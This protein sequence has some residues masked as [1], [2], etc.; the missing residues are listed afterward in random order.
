MDADETRIVF[1]NKEIDIISQKINHFDNLRL[2]TRQITIALWVGVVGFGLN[3]S[4]NNYS[5]FLFFLGSLIPLPFWYIESTYRRYYKGWS[6]RFKAIR[7]FL[8]D[9]YYNLPD[10]KKVLYRDFVDEGL[11]SSDF[12]LFDYWGHKTI[13]KNIRKE[14][15]S[16]FGSIMNPNIFLIYFPMVIIAAIIGI[17]NLDGIAKN[18]TTSI[19]ALFFCITL[20]A[21]II[22]H[23]KNRRKLKHH[24][25]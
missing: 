17:F 18:I 16:L 22:F 20:L 8:R 3:S 21:Y 23:L 15:V 4:G 6:E 12:P 1:L 14:K 10:G 2:K 11:I 7:K 9:G 19:F 24:N 5:V 13:D 25:Q